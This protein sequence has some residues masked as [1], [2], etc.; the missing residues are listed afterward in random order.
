MFG[1]NRHRLAIRLG[2]RRRRQLLHPQPHGFSADLK[3][4]PDMKLHSYILIIISLISVGCAF[5]RMNK[6]LY[7][8]YGEKPTTGS[9]ILTGTMDVVTAPVQAVIYGGSFV[10]GVFHPDKGEFE[11]RVCPACKTDRPS[12]QLVPLNDDLLKITCKSC[13]SVFHYSKSHGSLELI[14]N[15]IK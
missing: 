1:T 5:S 6:S 3:P 7:E 11:L 4:L 14:E 8:L 10:C 2:R 9:Y 13:E 12:Y 15:K